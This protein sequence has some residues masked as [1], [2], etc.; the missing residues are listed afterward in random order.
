MLVIV[1]TKV[2]SADR[3]SYDDDNN[4]SGGGGKLYVDHVRLTE[5]N[6]PFPRIDF[7]APK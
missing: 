3:D 1:R 7:I 5:S 4:S 2:D 6:L